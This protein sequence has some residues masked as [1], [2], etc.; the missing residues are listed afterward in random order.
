MLFNSLPFLFVFFPVVLIGFLLV[1]RLGRIAAVAWL[2]AA[3]L[4][5]YAY[6]NK[7]FLVL[8]LGSIVFNFL[9][10]QAIGC[11]VNRTGWQQRFLWA[12]LA[13][14]LALLGYFK[15]W[16]PL[17]NSLGSLAHPPLGFGSVTLPL[18]I[19][20]FTLTQIAYLVDL[21]QGEANQ[22]SLIEH[23]F[24]VG[25]F[26][27]LIAGP[28]LH[29]R[30]FMPQVAKGRTLRLHWEDLAVGLTCFV[31]GLFKKIVI[32]DQIAASADSLFASPAGQPLI[33]VWSG[34]LSYAVQLYFD[35]SGYS[36]MAIGL[37]RM[38]SLRF[39]MNFNSPYKAKSI[40][41]FWQRWHMTLTNFLML[42]IYNPIA[43]AINRQRLAA[44]RAIGRKAVITPEGFLRI[45]ALPTLVTMV[46]AGVW[47]GAGRQFLAFGLLHGI[48]ICLNHAWRTF[49][50]KW[51]A[52]LGSAWLGSAAS[53]LVTFLAVVSAQIF[54]RADSIRDA[55]AVVR[56]AIGINGTGMFPHAGPALFRWV[57]LGLL[58][59]VI[60]WFPNTQE[61]L[62]QSAD[63]E[64]GETGKFR[65][66]PSLRWQPTW[67]W[68]AAIAGAFFVSLVLL[69]PA[70]RF[71]YFQF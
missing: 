36:D 27:H 35:F 7:A 60:W 63:E 53:V 12:G 59:A 20:F 56:G 46:I 22:L 8:L 3:S 43:L 58:F 55:F 66:L 26:P 31:I 13:G 45:I 42:Y 51:S 62:S 57:A 49:A 15:Y 6:W 54:F 33:R 71:L 67:M 52:A 2:A 40:I 10:A 21:Q 17:L 39:P 23:L 4:V 34:V 50:P 68:T 37:A 44:G 1:G 32:A 48:F 29:H 5:F 9:C 38:F 25:F 61:I 14:N 41:E 16:F 70:S 11:V 47:H 65:A 24:F 19:S 28:I 69:K 18:G 64:G 30:E